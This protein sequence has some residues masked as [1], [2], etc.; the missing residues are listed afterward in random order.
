MRN[1]ILFKSHP[2]NQLL[3]QDL[4]QVEVYKLKKEGKK[5]IKNTEMHV[6]R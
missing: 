2:L 6:V 1:V 4:F 3:I 5:E